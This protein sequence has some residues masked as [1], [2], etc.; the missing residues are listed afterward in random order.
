MSDSCIYVTNSAG[1]LH[2][3]IEHSNNENSFDNT[4]SDKDDHNRN[5]NMTIILWK[6]E[7]IDTPNF[8][9]NTTASGVRLNI[10]DT[11]LDSP[12]KIFEKI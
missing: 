7:N 8:N 2:N 10:Q 9:F 1:T 11:P 12:I 4:S 5:F 3:Q 6:D